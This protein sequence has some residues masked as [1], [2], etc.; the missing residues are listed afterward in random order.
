MRK[1]LSREGVGLV[2]YNIE[3]KVVNAINLR[4]SANIAA[5]RKLLLFCEKSPLLREQPSTRPGYDS[6]REA[7][8]YVI[9]H[10]RFI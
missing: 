5:S 3:S 4:V 10:M 6:T 7:S 9:Y 2:V 8:H 1:E